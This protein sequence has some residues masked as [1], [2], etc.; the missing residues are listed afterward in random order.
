MDTP[1]DPPPTAADH[2]APGNRV[3]LLEDNTVEIDFTD[4]E[5]IIFNARG[6]GVYSENNRPN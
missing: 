4:E 1:D 6:W 5:F 2:C 3:R